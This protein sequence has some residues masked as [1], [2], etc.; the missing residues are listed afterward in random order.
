MGDSK[1]IIDVTARGVPERAPEGR[2][3]HG[4]AAPSRGRRLYVFVGLF[5]CLAALT[6]AYCFLRPPVYRAEASL[7][8]K[9]T[10]A[11][12]SE[13][14]PTND[15]SV[16][17]SDLVVAHQVLTSRSILERVGQEFASGHGASEGARSLSTDH[18]VGM[19]GAR[20][21]PDGNIIQLFVEGSDRAEAL[22]V[23]R[24]W[25]QVYLRAFEESQKAALALDT[26]SL[27]EELQALEARLESKRKELE[28][29]RQV[30]D[31]VSLEREENR[32]VSKLKGLNESLARAQEAQV[33]AESRLKALLDARA[34]GE[35]ILEGRELRA[36]LSMQERAEALRD[37][38][39]G[40]SQR[41][42]EKYMNLDPKVRGIRAQL[43]RIERR[44]ATTRA[45]AESAALDKARQDV[46]TA[47]RSVAQLE[48]QIAEQEGQ[49]RQFNA[50]FARHQ[51]LVDEL[52]DLETLYRRRK[53]Q[54]IQREVSPAQQVPRL[55][56]LEPPQA[57]EVPVRPHYLRDAAIGMGG[58]LLVSLF[59]LWLYEFLLRLP[60]KEE[61]SGG[62]TL[63]FQPHVSPGV[64]PPSSP[65]VLLEGRAG[66][67][68]GPERELSPL[69][70]EAMIRTAGPVDRALVYLMLTGLPGEE[71]ARLRWADV[72]VEGG[73][74]RLSGNPLRSIPL[75]GL[76]REVL[77]RLADA[78][79]EAPS[80]ASEPVFMNENSKAMTEDEIRA[81]LIFLAQE[82]CLASPATVTPEVLRHTYLL[83]L[84][85]QG[86]RLSALEQIV[87]PVGPSFVSRYGAMA[88]PGPG[89]GPE[90]VARVLPVFQKT[91]DRG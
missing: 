16:G 30:N 85:R 64:E 54:R 45:E 73:W 3:D 47:R 46:E 38:I 72:D 22:Q 52:K 41:Y 76:G 44:I 66:E 19:V 63:I 58:A 40:L 55:N 18:I 65:R 34:R 86:I 59:G 11:Q 42:T 89:R 14:A 23:L 1:E 74:I 80:D 90:D 43:E 17:K 21:V 84:V 2:A 6:L 51:A 37:Q 77:R 62:P 32:L 82:A 75:V 67:A 60:R 79:E 12:P 10:A 88:P 61:P 57:G 29:F 25:I 53:E 69:E 9:P 5:G 87:G 68:S 56:V 28:L 83:F 4:S 49:A 20:M 13:L 31:I 48:A 7:I 50:K 15:S 70:I 39:R 26:A 8:L 78:R 71:V 24:T 33:T 35:D 27:D 36:V 81:R 91:D